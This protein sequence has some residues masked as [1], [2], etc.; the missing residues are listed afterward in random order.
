MI[1]YY[2]KDNILAILMSNWF[3]ITYKMEYTW[4]LDDNVDEE[5]E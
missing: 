5:S 4:F 1:M 3:Q 2:F